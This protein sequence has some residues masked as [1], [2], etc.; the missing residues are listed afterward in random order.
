MEYPNIVYGHEEEIFNSYTREGPMVGTKMM[1]E[2]GRLFRFAENGSAA[3]VIGNLNQGEVPHATNFLDEDLATLAA[4]VTVLTGVDSTGANMAISALVN[5]YV[6]SDTAVLP[7][8]RIKDNTLITAGG[9]SGTITLYNPIPTAIVA[10]RTI[11]Y[12][13]NPWRDVIIHDSPNTA[14]LTGVCKLAL[15]VNAFGWLQTAGPASVYYKS[16][17][18]AVAGVG[19]PVGASTAI[20]GSVSG[21][22]IDSEDTS[23][24]VGTQLGI[25]ES[26]GEQM[27]IFMRLE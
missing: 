12:F 13:K 22:A 27:A 6:R 24:I 25:I 2:D 17:T 5:G 1:V 7:L 19:D 26:T 15:A 3:L 23:E 8:M 14:V 21:I 9:N 4:G 18:T 10:A 16:D 11:S 20:D